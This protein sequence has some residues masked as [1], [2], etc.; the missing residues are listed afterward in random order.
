MFHNG[1]WTICPRCNDT[2]PLPLEISGLCPACHLQALKGLSLEEVEQALFILSDGQSKPG[3]LKDA[4]SRF[5]TGPKR[6]KEILGLS[7]EENKT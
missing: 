5:A 7:E 1:A 3:Q 4:F 2:A 6:L